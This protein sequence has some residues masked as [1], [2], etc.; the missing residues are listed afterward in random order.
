MTVLALIVALIAL[1]VFCLAAFVVVRTRV[2]LLALGLA[3]LTI[4]W[5]FQTISVGH[6]VH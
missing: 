2:N 4:A 5:I 6:H 3:L 1:T